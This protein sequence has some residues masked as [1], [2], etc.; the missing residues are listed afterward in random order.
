MEQLSIQINSMEDAVRGIEAAQRKACTA[1]IEIGYILRKADDAELYKEKGYSSI[2]VFAEREYGWDQSQTSRFMS[3]NREYSEGGYSC[4]LQERYEGYGQA[5]LAEML[6]LPEGL[7]EEITPEMKRDDIRELKKDYRAAEETRQEEQFRE[8]FAPAQTEGALLEKTA[9]ALLNQTTY[10]QRIP[11]LWPLMLKHRQ[12]ET[13]NEMDVLM[14]LIPGGYGHAR[15]QSYMC[16]FRREE[17]SIMHGRDK[18]RH[19]YTELLD[20]IANLSET[21]EFDTPENWYQT[22]FGKEFPG[23]LREEEKTPENDEN[24]KGNQASGNPE[25][26]AEKPAKTIPKKEQNHTLHTGGIQ[27]K[28]ESGENPPTEAPEKEEN[29]ENPKGNQ[30]LEGQTEIGDFA[31]QMPITCGETLKKENDEALPCTEPAP[32]HLPETIEYNEN[33]KGNQPLGGLADIMEKKC[34]YCCGSKEI[35]SI[36]YAFFISLSPSGEG[37]IGKISAPQEHELIRF[38]YCPKCGRKLKK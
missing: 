21:A 20:T 15:V 23:K 10:A 2:F 7:R 28:E 24:P 26:Q 18:E 13:V 9:R 32:E 3:I 22:V 4:T 38:E 12:G 36:N 1:F 34:P 27:K 19:S 35:Y 25:N 29:N 16:F 5:K 6:K 17:M 30:P 8:A 33:P 37:K 31:E 11:D 14:A